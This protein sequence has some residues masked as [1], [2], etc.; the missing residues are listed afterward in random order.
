MQND[1]FNI[2]Y[3][4]TYPGIGVSQMLIIADK[5]GGSEIFSSKGFYGYKNVDREGN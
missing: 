1:L 2:V 4:F 3:F 5:G